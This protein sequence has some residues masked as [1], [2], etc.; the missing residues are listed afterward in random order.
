M[1]RTKVSVLVLAGLCLAF[2]GGDSKAKPMACYGDSCP[3]SDHDR[4][5]ICY[6]QCD[7]ELGGDLVFCQVASPDAATRVVCQSVAFSH[8]SRCYRECLE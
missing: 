8:W 1:R 4:L 3:I 7:W 2:G 6:T 5:S